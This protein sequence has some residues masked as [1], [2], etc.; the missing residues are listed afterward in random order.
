[1]TT[2]PDNP[3]RVRVIEDLGRTRLTVF[4]RLL[5][6]IPHFVWLGI[7]TL[8][9]VIVA[10]IAWFIVLFRGKLPD[11][12]HRFFTMYIRYATH[13]NAYLNLAANP[14]PGFLGENGYE[15]DLDFEPAAEQNRWKTGFRFVLVIPA[16]LLAA[17]LGGGASGGFTTGALSYGLQ[18]S[19][20]LSGCAFLIWFYALANGRA[21][22]GLARLQWY[23]LHYG[24]QAAAYALL[25][26][27]R[28]PSADPERVGV[29]WPAPD[30][31]VRLTREADDGL[32]SRLTV[33][34][35]V[36]LAF[37][38]FVWLT[39]WA[40]AAVVAGLVNWVVTL[41]RGQSP[42]ALHRFLAAYVRYQTHVLAFVT[43]VSNPFP[44]FAGTA[45]SYPVDVQIDPPE[46][47]NR[48][49]VAFRIFLALPAFIVGSA[50]GTAMWVAAFLGWFASL[51]TGRMPDALRKLGL[52]ALRYN[53]QTAAYGTGLLTPR[54]PYAGPPA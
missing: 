28:Y 51:A 19:G 22:E 20:V 10:F 48:W 5:L 46:R 36:L 21:P 35:R 15:I 13:V 39:L 26:T 33:F 49:T 7:W 52:F 29:P 27:D 25:V 24:G 37:P 40:V 8:G 31:P 1:L 43:L 54:Y 38:H 11:G 34:F 17:V 44:G 30:H 16:L 41:V 23:C 18:T 3:V 14:F 50:L 4:F 12:L 42:D 2:P 53:A 9:V 47:Q 45:G 32:R 6:T